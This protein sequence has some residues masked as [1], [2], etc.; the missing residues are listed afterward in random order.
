MIKVVFYK[1][2]SQLVN[3]LTIRINPELCRTTALLAINGMYDDQLIICYL[4]SISDK[5]NET[6]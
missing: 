2:V 3:K 4:H 5:F 6:L 1:E